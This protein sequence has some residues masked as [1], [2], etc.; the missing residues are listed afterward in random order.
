MVDGSNAGSINSASTYVDDTLFVG[1]IQLGLEWTYALR[2]LPANAFFRT[3]IEYQR[4]DGGPGFSE[5]GSFASYT[6]SGSNT[7]TADTETSAASP[8]LDLVGLTL[9]TGL[10][11]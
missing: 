6:G 1:E 10:T 8:Q 2:C 3:A 9:G 4:W 5:A 7:S 11:W